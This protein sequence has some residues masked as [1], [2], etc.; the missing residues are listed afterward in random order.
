MM[1]KDCHENSATLCTYKVDGGHCWTHSHGFKF[2]GSHRMK[3]F[4]GNQNIRLQLL[5][6]VEAKERSSQ[7]RK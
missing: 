7:T 2:G 1:P 5:S 6:W 3:V 4:K